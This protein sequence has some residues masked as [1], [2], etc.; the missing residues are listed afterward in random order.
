[1][2]CLHLLTCFAIIVLSIC[3]LCQSSGI[4]SNIYKINT[5]VAPTGTAYNSVSSRSALDCAQYCS[6]DPECST[7]TIKE[8]GSVME[9]EAYTCWEAIQNTTTPGV[10]TYTKEGKR[11]MYQSMSGHRVGRLGQMGDPL[12][13]DNF[14]PPG[15]F[16]ATA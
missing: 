1:M 10:N 3:K 12:D 8:F 6:K 16:H 13:I 11:L 7:F 5:D 2:A 15:L 4:T 14:I 9:C